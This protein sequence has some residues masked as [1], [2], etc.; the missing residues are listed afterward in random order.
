EGGGAIGALRVHGSAGKAIK[1]P[2][3]LQSFS[4]NPFF[5]GNPDLEPERARTAEIGVEQRIAGDRARID[6]TWFGNRY[7]NIIALGPPDAAFSSRYMNIGL[8]RAR[9]MELAGAVALVRGLRARAGYTL[10][11]SKILESTSTNA[12]FK[13]GNPALRRPRHSGFMS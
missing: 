12:V 3:V 13:V 6:V 8:T 2:T 5:L 4:P 9:G 7:R 10:T 11:D 1:E